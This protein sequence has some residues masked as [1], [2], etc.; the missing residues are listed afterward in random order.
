MNDPIY[1]PRFYG[2]HAAGS[3][4]SA[5][6]VLPE[7]FDIVGLPSSILDVGCGIATWGGAAR[8]L[9]VGD[10]LGIDG[11]WVPKNQLRVPAEQFLPADL[12]QL[13]RL[14]VDR[15]FDL[16]I[17]IEV[18]EHLPEA[19]AAKLVNFLTTHADRV[20]FGAA[21]PGQGGT[22]HVN[23]QWQFYWAEIFAACGFDAFDIIRPRI[24][25][26]R[27]IEYWYRQNT[28]LYAKCDSGFATA[29][30]RAAIPQALDY[31]LPELY[32]DKLKQIEKPKLRDLIRRMP[33]AFMNDIRRKFFQRPS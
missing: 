13:D 32:E 23:E 31:I 6:L 11:D 10:Y 33:A 18:A 26:N 14:Q 20:V 16:A 15:H 22:N 7:V 9:G 5:R 12:S 1:K 24:A 30:T 27:E 21:V 17:C 29:M 4:Q 19:M 8:E 25:G 28:I 3:S 2:G